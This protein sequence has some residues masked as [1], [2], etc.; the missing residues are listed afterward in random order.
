MEMFF[1]ERIAQLL[2]EKVRGVKVIKS[3]EVLA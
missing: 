2:A 3:W 1:L